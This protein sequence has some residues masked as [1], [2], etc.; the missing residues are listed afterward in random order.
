MSD[1][2]YMRLQCRRKDANF[3]EELGFVEDGDGDLES[4]V[5]MVDDQAAGGHYD[6]LECHPPKGVPFWGF[7]GSGIEYGAELFA[8]DGEEYAAIDCSEQGD[9]MARIGFYPQG[10]VV[11]EVD[12]REAQA[13]DRIM[14]RLV[15]MLGL[16]ERSEKRP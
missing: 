3:F 6:D 9:P 12:L 8:S 7:H 2:C 13:Y 5:V 11:S 4:L 14:D 16:P 10:P 15:K 1:R